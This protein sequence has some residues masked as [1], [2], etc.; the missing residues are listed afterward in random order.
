MPRPVFAR[1]ALIG[2]VHLPALPGAPRYER[3]D[4]LPLARVLERATADARALAGEGCH[5]LL[6]ENFGD[7]PFHAEH[8]PPESVAALALAVAAVRAAAPGV[9]VGVNVLRNDARAALGVCAA[10]GASFLRVNVLAGAAITD[11]GLVQGRAAELLRER[12]RLAPEVA[13]FADAHVKHATPLGRES[14]AEAVEDLVSRALCDAVVVSGIA[15]GRPP[16]AERVR[17]AARAARGA[18]V[19]VGSGLDLDNAAALLEHAAGAIVG[20]ALKFDGRVEE[21]VDPARVR[22]LRMRFDALR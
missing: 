18:P 9:A 22:A 8:V 13:L 3:P 1:P 14:L 11:Q 20:T 16:T 7:V 10:T 12:A 19:F 21:P 2:V 4:G 5:A 6:V 15:T 17:E